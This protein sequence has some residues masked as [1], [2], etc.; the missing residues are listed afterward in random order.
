MLLPAASGFS[1]QTFKDAVDE[2][3]KVRL[4]A[5]PE[6]VFEVFANASSE[7]VAVFK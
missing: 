4:N 5:L 2:Q 6:G 3:V 7:Q 1:T